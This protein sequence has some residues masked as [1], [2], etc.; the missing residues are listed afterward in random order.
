MRNPNKGKGKQAQWLRDHANH[1]DPKCLIW[2]FYRLPNGYGQLGYLGRMRYAHRMMCE[3]AHGAPPPDKPEAAHKCG[4][5]HQGCVNPKHLIWK[6]KAE[7]RRDSTAH[8]RG[9]R[10]RFGNKGKLRPDD[11][12]IILDLKGKMRQVDIA[13]RFGVDWTTISSIYCGKTH[14]KTVAAIL[15]A[16]R[17]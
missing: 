6:S 5:G 1:A 10:N 3:L 9:G 8:G 14:K 16:S 15:S 17:C 4:S 11:I 7:N 13:A 12:R 2:P